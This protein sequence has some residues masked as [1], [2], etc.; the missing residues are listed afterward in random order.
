M[1][2]YRN[3]KHV[4]CVLFNFYSEYKH[5]ADNSYIVFKTVTINTNTDSPCVTAE[6]NDDNH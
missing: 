4:K 6:T 1:D 2:T 3:F 5:T